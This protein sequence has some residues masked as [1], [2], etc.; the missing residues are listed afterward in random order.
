[1]CQRVTHGTYLE[2]FRGTSRFIDS[3]LFVPNPNPHEERFMLQMSLLNN[4]HVAKKNKDIKNRQHNLSFPISIFT[5]NN[6]CNIILVA[7][8]LPQQRLC[9]KENEDKFFWQHNLCCKNFYSKTY[10]AKGFC[11]ITFAIV[12]TLLSH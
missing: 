10:V 8:V 9:C 11:N 5:R 7:K 6:I 4:I 1:M 2:T 3:S 12:K